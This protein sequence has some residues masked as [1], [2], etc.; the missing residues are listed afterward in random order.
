MTKKKKTIIIIIVLI[1]MIIISC[2]IYISVMNINIRNTR[3]TTRLNNISLIQWWIEQY[4]QNNVVYPN[5]LSEIINYI[6]GSIPIDPLEWKTINWCKFWY[7]YS[8]KTDINWLENWAY[9]ISTC[10]EDK[11]HIDLRAKYD[12]WTDPLRYEKSFWYF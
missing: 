9:K 7:Q 1:I 4:Y 6:G 11:K 5:N 8:V 2:F 12:W 3:D 10:L